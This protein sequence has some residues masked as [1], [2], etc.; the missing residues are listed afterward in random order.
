MSTRVIFLGAPGAG[1]GTQARALAA[2][3]DGAT[4]AFA[5]RWHAIAREWQ[6]AELNDLVDRH[7][8]WYP[9][10]SR[11]PMDPKTRTYALV[12]GEDY[13]RHPLDAAWVLRRFP[14]E[15]NLAR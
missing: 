12:N 5:R 6:F 8:R 14:A 10:E 15:L 3:C 4:E 9:A 11:L 13:R 2:E 1:K 7:N